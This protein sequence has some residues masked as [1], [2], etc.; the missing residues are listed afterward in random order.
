MTRNISKENLDRQVFNLRKEMVPFAGG[1]VF[2]RSDEARRRGNV[3]LHIQIKLRVSL[4]CDFL[5]VFI[6]NPHHREVPVLSSGT[7]PS[8]PAARGGGG[9]GY[10]SVPS[11]TRGLYACT[12][13]DVEIPRVVKSISNFTMCHTIPTPIRILLLFLHFLSFF[14]ALPEV[15]SPPPGGARGSVHRISTPVNRYATQNGGGGEKSRK[16]PVTSSC[17]GRGEN[18]FDIY[19]THLL[20]PLT[21]VVQ[22]RLDLC[23]VCNTVCKT[24][25]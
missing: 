24:G 1:G 5:K 2:T 3:H 10:C 14:P 17:P 18:I 12:S 6:P 22:E 25:I 13:T 9:G 11:N 21:F 7:F 20:L 16:K 23:S 4:V 8:S 19:W 15:P